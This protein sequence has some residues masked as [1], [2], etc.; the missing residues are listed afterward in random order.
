MTDAR[1]TLQLPTG[2]A[3][4]PS[5]MIRS[6]RP[7]VEAAPAIEAAPA[8]PTPEPAAVETKRPV[9]K[10]AAPKRTTQSKSASQVVPERSAEGS[11]QKVNFYIDSVIRARAVAAFMATSYQEEDDSWSDFAEKAIL[12]EAE[13]REREYN[14]GKPFKARGAVKTGRPLKH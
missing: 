4:E 2:A 1:R 5:I 7:P 13:R 9:A 14:G 11:R 8:A 6:R 10:S 3:P 12:A